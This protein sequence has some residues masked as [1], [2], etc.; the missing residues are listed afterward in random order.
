MDLRF[1]RDSVVN[2]GL[3]ETDRKIPWTRRASS[4]FSLVSSSS[5]TFFLSRSKDLTEAAVAAAGGWSFKLE[6]PRQDQDEGRAE[7]IRLH[8]WAVVAAAGEEALAVADMVAGAAVT[9]AEV[10]AA[11]VTG[12]TTWIPTV[13]RTVNAT[14]SSI[15]P[16]KATATWTPTA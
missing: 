11:A 14:I 15:P 10:L 1:T 5:R 4:W 6:R 16:V 8:F 2:V 3:P 12:A 13:I 9:E 7:E